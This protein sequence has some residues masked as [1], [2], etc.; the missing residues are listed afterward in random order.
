VLHKFVT[1]LL[2]YLYTYALT[3]PGPT[4]S[5]SGNKCYRTLKGW[6]PFLSFKQCQST[7]GNSKTL[8]QTGENH[9]QWLHPFLIPTEGRAA[10]HFTSALWCSC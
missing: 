10:T 4:R 8:I 3:A 1:Y 5:T 2:T 6:M 9:P 7:E